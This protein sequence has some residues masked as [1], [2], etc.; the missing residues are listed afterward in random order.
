MKGKRMN[1]TYTPGGA[2]AVR[3]LYC[4]RQVDWLEIQPASPIFWEP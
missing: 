2:I 4:F 3:E 1:V